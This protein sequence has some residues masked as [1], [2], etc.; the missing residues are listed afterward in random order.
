MAHAII[1]VKSLSYAVVEMSSV[2]SIDLTLTHHGDETSSPEA[3][4]ELGPYSVWLDPSDE[5]HWR[6][7]VAREARSLLSAPIEL[8]SQWPANVPVVRIGIKG[9]PLESSELRLAIGDQEVLLHG[10]FDETDASR[11]IL[12]GPP[13]VSPESA[14]RSFVLQRHG[15][16]PTPGARGEESKELL[17][18]RTSMRIGPI[19]WVAPFVPQISHVLGESRSPTSRELNREPDAWIE[20]VFGERNQSIFGADNPRVM[21]VVPLPSEW[22]E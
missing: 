10:I 13:D 20:S 16:E 18:V 15:G 17:S 8:H 6:A 1:E 11:L 19:E 5:S 3:I 22:A 14:A 2:E 21:K 12:W 9:E 4:L 7:D